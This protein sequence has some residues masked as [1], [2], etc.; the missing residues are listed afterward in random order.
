MKL[1]MIASSGGVTRL[2]LKCHWGHRFNNACFEKI[3]KASY[4]EIYGSI[5]RF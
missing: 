3:L 1:M 4:V 5:H 2:G